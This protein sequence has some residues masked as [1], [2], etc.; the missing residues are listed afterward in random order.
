MCCFLICRLQRRKET[1]VYRSV[2]KATEM[3][4]AWGNG[5]GIGGNGIG[6]SGSR[7]LR[8]FGIFVCVHFLKLLIL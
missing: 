7:S 3:K 4:G 5:A 2:Q 8:G 1:G 6:V